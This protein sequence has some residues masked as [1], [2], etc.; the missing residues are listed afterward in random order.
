[1][2]FSSLILRVFGSPDAYPKESLM[3]CFRRFM[4]LAA[5]L[6]AIASLLVL[7]LM[8]GAAV[9]QAAGATFVASM[10]GFSPRA[11]G[12]V[13]DIKPGFGTGLL[14]VFVAIAALVV[15]GHLNQGGNH[16]PRREAG[17]NILPIG[18][19]Y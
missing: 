2:S 13:I 15:I 6:A 1:M 19:F 8:I 18:N 11:I 16:E 7:A 14:L 10:L 4:G 5:A 9:A 17:V 3:R 12:T